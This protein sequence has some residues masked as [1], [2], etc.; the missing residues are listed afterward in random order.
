[1][2]I[3]A[4][5]NAGVCGFHTTIEASSSDGV[6]VSIRIE[7]DCPRVQAMAADLTCVDA[8]QQVLRNPFIETTPALLAAKHKLHSVCL[9]P[10]G[11]LKAAEAAAGLALPAL[12][13]IKLVRAE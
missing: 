9:V 8:F 6:N 11:I 13:E 1:M 5:V 3:V 7:S 4:Q 10:I 2:D 12:C